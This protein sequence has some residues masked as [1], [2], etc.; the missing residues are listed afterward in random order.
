MLISGLRPGVLKTK[1]PSAETAP[2][3][4]S[5]HLTISVGNENNIETIAVAIPP[6][7]SKSQPHVETVALK[8]SRLVYEM[9]LMVI[10]RMI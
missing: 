2:M 4:M 5:V 3:P 8:P 1:I 9:A 7:M 6:T 10:A